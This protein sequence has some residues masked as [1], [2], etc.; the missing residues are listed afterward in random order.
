MAILLTCVDDVLL[1]GDYEEEVEGMVN[2]QLKRY[3]G[4]DPGVLSNIIGVALMATDQ[5]TK[6]DQ[7]PYTMSIAING[8][9][10]FDMR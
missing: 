6:L 1:S 9:G 10:S 4:R 3:E 2:H 8:M 5:G 7:A